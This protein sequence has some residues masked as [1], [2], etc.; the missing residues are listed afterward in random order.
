M[1]SGG[2]QH[3]DDSTFASHDEWAR[4][5]KRYYQDV[6]TYDWVDVAD[7]LR[8]P[9]AIFHRLRARLVQGLVVEYIK[10][11]I[12][13]DAGCGTGLNLRLLPAGSV[14][15]DIN[16]RNIAV[17]EQRLPNYEVVLGDVEDM[18]FEDEHFA[19]VICTEVLEHVPDPHTA[20]KEIWRVLKPGGVLIGTVPARTPIWK[21]RFLSST[22]PAGEP[23]HNEYRVAEV[24][25]MLGYFD[26]TF[27]RYALGGASVAFVGKRPD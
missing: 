14:G 16:P 10:D 24:R 13:L 11:G 9:E 5:V 4:W 23:F 1:H 7:N 2:H 20:L 3:I 8:G 15:L 25:E 19:G 18:P 22:C 17:L 6:E 12:I 21:L 27:I 26:V